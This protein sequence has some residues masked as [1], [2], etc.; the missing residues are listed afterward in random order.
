[1]NK[2]V[3][4]IVA[5]ALVLGAGGTAAL[6]TLLPS[7]GDTAA[8]PPPEPP[9][10]VDMET[11]LVNINAPQGDRFAKLSVRLTVLPGTLAESLSEDPVL[12]A[13]MRDRVL[14]LVTS[15]TLAELIGPVGK[16]GLRREIK[17]HLDPL[18]DE[19]EIQEVL[20]SEF[21]VQ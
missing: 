4:I 12:K 9:G 20:F 6:L 7:D 5:A 1:M 14:T 21:V 8:A 19:G 13:R 18:L 3:I 11:F 10:I 16:E 2:K 17:A 15:K